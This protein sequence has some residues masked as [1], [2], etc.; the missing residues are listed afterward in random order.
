MECDLMWYENKV[1]TT[2][3]IHFQ[4]LMDE[5]NFRCVQKPSWKDHLQINVAC[6]GML[7]WRN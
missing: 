4:N 7:T 3:R 1:E 2:M 5:N 6:I